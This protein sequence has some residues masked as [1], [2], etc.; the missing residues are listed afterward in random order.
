MRYFAKLRIA[1]KLTVIVMGI[2]LLFAI[3]SGGTHACYADRYHAC[4]TGAARTE[5]GG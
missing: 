3:L 4:I 1:S 5:R 2:V